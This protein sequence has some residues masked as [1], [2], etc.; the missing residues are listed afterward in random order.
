M[1]KMLLIRRRMCYHSGGEEERWSGVAWHAPM[2]SDHP[3]QALTHLERIPGIDEYT[4]VARGSHRALDDV[5]LDIA[6]HCFAP[7]GHAERRPPMKSSSS[8]E[9]DDAV[10]PALLTLRTTICLTPACLSNR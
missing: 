4:G 9:R 2:P 6:S 7:G 3:R 5:S 10:G 1:R 8:G